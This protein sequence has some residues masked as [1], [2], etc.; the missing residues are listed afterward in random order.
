VTLEDM[1]SLQMDS[2]SLMSEDFIPLLQSAWAKVGTDPALAEFD[3]RPELASLV[4]LISVDWDRRMVRDSPGAVAFHAFA[5]FVT[6]V[7]AEDDMISF[8]YER[9]LEAAPFYILKVA[10]LALR[11][12][13]PNGAAL[14]QEGVD[15][16]VL[17]GLDRTAAFLTQ[18]FGG[19]SPDGYRWSDMHVTNFD[20]AFGLGMPLV[21]VPSDGG[22]DTVN[23][24]HSLFRR[25]T[26]V[27]DQW[28]S[29][30]GPV[31]RLVGRFG[32]DGTPE[33]W[34]NFP[35]GNVAD[36]ASPH[37][38]DMLGDWLDGNYRKLAFTR[39]E[40]DARAEHSFEIQRQ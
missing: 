19:V 36:P 5:H 27:L 30:Y 2:H 38:D 11:G 8:L 21:T 6:E 14:L 26:Q 24:A 28:V 40:V 17:T 3:N 22:E 1:Q 29:D 4:Q 10:A 7:A 32:D 13:Y 9:V 37:F 15:W 18:R 23:V 31:E 25:D 34:V 39:S 16:I 12:E 35:L 33:V 20:N